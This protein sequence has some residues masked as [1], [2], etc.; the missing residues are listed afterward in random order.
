MTPLSL[1]NPCPR[2]LSKYHVKPR[3]SVAGFTLVEMLAVI[4]LISILAVLTVPSLTGLSAA[5]KFNSA[6]SGLSETLSLARQTA[7][8]RNTYVWVA[9]ALPSSTTTGSS[10]STLVVASTDGTNP[11]TDWS[12]TVTLPDS[13]LVVVTKP[14]SYLQTQFLEAGTLTSQQIPSL[15]GNGDPAVN[16]LAS[17]LTFKANSPTGTVTYSRVIE[18]TPSGLVYNG[19]NPVNFVEF[20]IEPGMTA[21]TAIDSKNVADLRVPF[22]T[23][24]TTIYRP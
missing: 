17:T 4:C 22:I 11:F 7:V 14:V 3:S 10:L 12:S 13:R 19:A 1:K 15:P 24:K 2:G 23:G 5:G 9:F 20:G 21:T 8:A 16:G 18:Y 6:V